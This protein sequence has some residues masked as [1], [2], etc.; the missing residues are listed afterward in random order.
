MPRKP[1]T[2][3][4]VSS[5]TAMRPRGAPDW[6]TAELLAETIAAW[7][8]YY[9]DDLTADQALEILLAAGRLFEALGDSQD[10][11]EPVLGPGPRQQP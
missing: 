6:V 11:E 3:S 2:K 4:N 1:P 10:E 7:Q 8:P 9:A 5:Q